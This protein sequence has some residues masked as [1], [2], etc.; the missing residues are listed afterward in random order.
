MPSANLFGDSSSAGGGGILGQATTGLFGDAPS[1]AA[2]PLE[3]EAGVEPGML[4]DA[5]DH[6]SSGVFGS[7]GSMGGLPSSSLFSASQTADSDV[8]FGQ[9]SNGGFGFGGDD[10]QLFPSSHKLST[11]IVLVK[12]SHSCCFSHQSQSAKSTSGPAAL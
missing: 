2:E 7:M 12:Q 8:G 11:T 3:L 5:A 10:C 9:P 6:S 1:T 4:N